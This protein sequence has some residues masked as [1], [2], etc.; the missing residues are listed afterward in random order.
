M[1]IKLLEFITPPS[2]YN[3]YFT[4]KT[5]WEEKF[6]VGEFTPVN[7]KCFDSRNVRK[8]REIKDSDK[9]IILDILLNSKRI[10]RLVEKVTQ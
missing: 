5:F 3:G 6:T 9:Y 8:H 4:R 10:R 2:I 1:K 7:M